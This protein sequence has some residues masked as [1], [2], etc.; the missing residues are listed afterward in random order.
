MFLHTFTRPGSLRAQNGTVFDLK[1]AIRFRL[2]HYSLQVN[3]D[4]VLLIGDL[5]RDVWPIRAPDMSW[6]DWINDGYDDSSSIIAV[7]NEDD[8]GEWRWIVPEVEGIENSMDDIIIKTLETV[9]SQRA[10][11]TEEDGVGASDGWVNGR[12][13]YEWVDF[14]ADDTPV[15]CS[16]MELLDT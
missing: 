9:R 6:T 16:M 15:T 7:P 2:M 4:I 3:S 10:D 14:I 5:G 1:R 11:L 8:G 13:V 12:D